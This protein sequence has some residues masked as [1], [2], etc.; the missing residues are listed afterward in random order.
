MPSERSVSPIPF[1]QAEVRPQGFHLNPLEHLM[2]KPQPQTK[3][4]EKKKSE[5]VTFSIKH[6][7][8]D[9]IKPPALGRMK[10]NLRVFEKPKELL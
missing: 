3:K 4:A 8:D 2:F 6:I 10:L 7:F 1:R 9:V 5:E